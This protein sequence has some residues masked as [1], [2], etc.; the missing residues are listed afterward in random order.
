MV[1]LRSL[2]VHAIL[3]G[4]SVAATLLFLE[5]SLRTIPA[6]WPP[7]AYARSRFSPELQLFVHDASTVY[8]GAT[9]TRR[10][11]NRDGFLDVEHARQ[12]PDGVR[13]VGFFGDSYVEA[14]QVRLED[15]FYRKLPT[16]IS[17]TPVEAFGFGISGWGTLHSLLAYRVL[18]ERY[19]LDRVVYLFVKND[20]G[21]Q[22]YR[23][24]R[25]SDPTARLSDDE[26]GFR[27]QVPEGYGRPPRRWAAFLD[28]N[29]LLVRLVRVQLRAL[30]KRRE[31]AAD[32]AV[33]PESRIPRENDYPST[34]PPELLEEA[35]LLTRRILVRFRDEVVRDG[36]GFSVL[37]VPRGNEELAGDL[38]PDDSW[39]P[40]LSRTCAE[41]DIELLDPSAVLRGA[42]DSGTKVYGD[43][44]TSAGHEIIAAFVAQHL[45]GEP[46]R[47]AP[48]AP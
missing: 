29:L 11:P 24:R 30:A 45:A 20:P 1:R 40:W 5:V 17:G 42:R 16:E 15:T 3:V 8:K 28:Q 7:G 22:H 39:L 31:I 46:A 44:W 27:V 2:L 21:D 35:K 23:V 25:G 32:A 19:D 6:L 37:Y 43:H 14:L 34:W 33:V 48:A 9:W 12:K 38:A 36:R 47:T 10:I 13:R 41:L 26:V 4:A 18:G